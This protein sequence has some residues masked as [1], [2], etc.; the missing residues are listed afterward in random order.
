MELLPYPLQVLRGNTNAGVPHLETD[1]PIQRHAGE[2]NE[3]VLGVA[4]RVLD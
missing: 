1:L 4:Q 2:F 3:A